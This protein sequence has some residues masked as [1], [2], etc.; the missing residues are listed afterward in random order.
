M[1][2][3]VGQ[4]DWHGVAAW[5][6]VSSEL[7][8]VM[9]PIMGA[10]IVSLLD[11]R[12]GAEWLIGP[13]TRPVK[14][15]AYGALFHEQDMAGWDEMFPTIVACP[16]PGPG[17]RHGANLP[18]H[19]EAWTL[20]WRV[21]HAG[22]GSLILTLDGRALPYRLTRAADCPEPA[23]LR[24]RYTLNNLGPDPMPYLW[25]PHPQFTCGP[26]GQV[27]LPDEITEVINTIP[28]SWGWG[29]PETRFSWPA[30]TAIDGSTV[31]ADLVGPPTLRRG[32]KFFTQPHTR[33][34]WAAIL[35]RDSGHWVRFE[36]NPAKTPYLGLWVDEG[37]LSFDSV[38]ALE[39]TT[40]WYDDLALA[41]QKRE[42]IF[43]PAGGTHEW[44]LMVRLGM[45]GQ[46]HP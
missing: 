2:T 6:L 20:P 37:A 32:R 31:R 13:G 15:V 23:T 44:T 21:V 11:R 1:E 28:E 17:A 45:D 30:A 42:V 46:P 3:L 33:S 35:R 19:G 18:D 22:E 12:T 34:A 8:A 26:D 14:P 5:T 7:S 27:I 40:G 36:W 24:L 16:Y 41:W 25:A 43:V 38:V 9:V 10:K 4:T 29:P 39:P